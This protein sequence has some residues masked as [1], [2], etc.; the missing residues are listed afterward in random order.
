M[1][2]DF[3][4]PKCRD[5]DFCH[6]ICFSYLIREVRLRYWDIYKYDKGCLKC[7]DRFCVKMDT[8]MR[9]S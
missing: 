1:S 5:I 6:K 3:V 7:I 9:N 2:A 4:R 8:P